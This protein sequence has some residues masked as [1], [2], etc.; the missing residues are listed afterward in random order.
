LLTDRTISVVV[1]CYRDAGSVHEMYRRLTAVLDEIT[2]SYEIIYVNDN[3]PDNA[4]ELLAELA[5][6]DPRLT[7]ISHSRNF[8]SQMAFTSGM[9][10]SVGDAVILMDGDLQDPPEVIPAL[11]AEWIQGFEVVYG[12]RERRQENA[13]KEL[14][15]KAFYRIYRRLSYLN[16]PLDAGDFSI[17]SRCVVDAILQMPER[18]RFL[19]G[20]RTWVGFRQKGVPYVRP[21]RFSGE[22]TNS[23][24]DNIRWAKR[25]IF[26]F[27]Y[28]P[29]E[30]ISML[31]FGATALTG[32]AILLYAL[33]YFLIPQSPRGFLTILVAV[34][35]LGA[36]QLFSLSIIAEYLG[37]IFEEVK[38]RP[39]YIVRET[40][41]DHRMN[42]GWKEGCGYETV[43][44]PARAMSRLSDRARSR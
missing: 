24:L 28:Q 38:M 22:S 25:G 21:E 18:D 32:V 9:Q 39:R 11:V 16:V 7:V 29:L 31:A 30:L 10:Q 6:T 2:P 4:A 33:F 23:L 44:Q 35:F 40:R 36:V 3:S 41:N 13:L 34:L 37:R 17:M 26:S 15:R 14:A 27:S 19:R 12:V 42:P 5:E 8:G 1:A 43:G 20:L